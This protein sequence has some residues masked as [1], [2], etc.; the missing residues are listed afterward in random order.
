[1]IPLPI[2]DLLPQIIASL[3]RSRTL[4]IAAPPGAGKTTRIPPAILHAGLL[5]ASQHL[6]MLQPRRVAARATA[7]RI[8]D[9]QG[10]TLGNQ[11]GY[12]VRFDR[13]LSA[14]TPLR[15]LTEGI[16]TRQLL[17]DPL[18][19]HTGA[20]ILDEF[21]ERS[22][23][24]DLA[25]ALLKEV[26]QARPDLLLI[27]MSATLDT[28]AISHYLGDCPILQSQGRLHPVHL[29]YHPPGPSL[30]LEQA[31]AFAA[32]D[33]LSS[34]PHGDILIFLPGAG[35]IH[36]TLSA[37]HD[38]NL[39]AK[40]LPLYGALPLSQQLEAIRPSADSQPRIICATNIAE[41]SLTIENV[42]AVI[43]TG[44]ERIAEYDQRRG[45]DRLHLIP[46]SQASAAQRTGRAGRVR[47]G[48]CI[49]L[50]S[51]K[52]FHTFKPYPTSE[53][54]RIDLA[55]T[56]LTLRAW[57]PS[58]DSTFD[59]FES[60]P[61]HAVQSAEH[62]LT[63][64]GAIDF[65]TGRLTSIGQKMLHIPAHP[66]LAR[67][68]TE[69]QSIGHLTAGAS[70]AALLSEPGLFPRRRPNTP[71]DSQPLRA[72]RSDLLLQLTE[73]ESPHRSTSGPVS[74]AAYQRFLKIRHQFER[75]L[76][77]ARQSPSS[78]DEP[79]LLR[80]LLAAYP[81][82]VCRRRPADPSSAAMVGGF[83]IRISP[84]STVRHDEFFLALELFQH[85]RAHAGQPLVHLASAIEPQWLE[86]MFPSAIHLR[87][88]AQ[89][90]EPSQRII[91]TRQK[92][93]LD[94]VL[95]EDRSARPDPQAATQCLREVVSQKRDQ[96]L[97][98]ESWLGDLLRR[99]DLI[100]NLYPQALQHS[101]DTGFPSVEQLFDSAC[102]NAL[103]L[104]QFRTNLHH[105]ADMH[106]VTWRRLLD[107]YAPAT[108]EL[109]TGHSQKLDWSNAQSHP[110]VRGPVLAVRIQELFGL[111]QTP[112]I[113]A[114]RLP[115]ILHLLGPNY[116]PVQVTDDLASFW[117]N[118]YPQVRK[119]LRARYPKHAWPEDPLTAPPQRRPTRSTR[120]TP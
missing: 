53:I 3:R 88:R 42:T 9:E 85:D 107:Q 46:I 73:L 97:Q 19:E 8:A 38:L 7:Q 48:S 103:S 10:W 12:H 69:A 106:L 14:T 110:T 22:I 70:L 59:W 25:I 17:D 68:L 4:V 45:L 79:T 61:P 60:P 5:P 81:D 24:T 35:E 55:Q 117:K 83:G 32:R 99:I 63:L 78:A 93:Y 34:N 105:I 104:A 120:H 118:T 114:G 28:S 64:L 23:N 94:L 102:T 112:R 50:Y 6:L 31:A 90:D 95:Q 57:N 108:I 87:D 40:A 71:Y 39:P 1:M 101:G 91:A 44:L 30:S 26:R 2:D 92:L 49:R 119:D 33:L 89:F 58:P 72:T 113:L 27:V 66:R 86:Q 96:L 76:P 84:E 75:C 36:R 43:D 47:S 52:T 115:V 18:L 109:P 65:T 51:E 54:H 62:L 111:A 80:L 15:I 67:L 98:Q 11:V 16:L 37:L 116:R 20:V 21:H 41:T 100:Q 29:S 13:K 82:R 56:L 77:H 74:S